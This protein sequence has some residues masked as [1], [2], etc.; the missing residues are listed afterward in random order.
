MFRYEWQILEW[1]ETNKQQKILKLTQFS[2]LFDEVVTI[3][4]VVLNAKIRD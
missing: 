3:G 4:L 1:D 2:L